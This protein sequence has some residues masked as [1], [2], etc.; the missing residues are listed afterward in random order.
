[1]EGLG[2]PD[3][4]EGL[5]GLHE[6]AARGVRRILW[7]GAAGWQ[8]AVACL[9]SSVPCPRGR[10][11]RPPPQHRRGVGVLLLARPKNGAGAVMAAPPNQKNVRPSPFLRARITFGMCPR[12]ARATHALTSYPSPGAAGGVSANTTDTRPTASRCRAGPAADSVR[13]TT[14]G[15]E[16]GRV[17]ITW[18]G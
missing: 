16:C 12:P 13:G 7:R 18:T 8:Q 14:A 3:H 17:P 1:V 4:L 5:R 9:G 11:S 15:G 10:A 2:R 6:L